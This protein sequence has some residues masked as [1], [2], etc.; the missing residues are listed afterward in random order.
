MSSRSKNLMGLH[1]QP[2]SVDYC[3]DGKSGRLSGQPTGVDCCF[4]LIAPL[5]FAGE[6]IT[7][8]RDLVS[9]APR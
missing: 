3:I 6:I 1:L 4:L 5:R 8:I 9:E 2:M 7:A